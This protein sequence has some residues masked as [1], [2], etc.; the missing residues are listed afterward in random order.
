MVGI[1]KRLKEAAVPGKAEVAVIDEIVEYA[2]A[3]DQKQARG[4]EDI[5][6]EGSGGRGEVPA[7]LV[8]VAKYRESEGQKMLLRFDVRLPTFS[9]KKIGCN[10]SN[11]TTGWGDYP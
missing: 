7:G 8:T 1:L 10:I 9:K 11:E 4:V 2:C 5:V 3:V 6:S